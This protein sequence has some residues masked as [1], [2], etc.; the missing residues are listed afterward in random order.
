MADGEASRRVIA[1]VQTMN[2]VMIASLTAKMIVKVNQQMSLRIMTDK[3]NDLMDLVIQKVRLKV[4]Q[5]ALK[6]IQMALNIQ[7]DH[8]IQIFR[9]LI[10]FRR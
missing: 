3:L 2:L 9:W 10:R 6:K 8:N 5:I 7:M 1:A 4:I